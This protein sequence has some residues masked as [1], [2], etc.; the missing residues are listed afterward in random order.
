MFIFYSA[1]LSSAPRL[2]ISSYPP[3]TCFSIPFSCKK[4][5]IHQV[6]QTFISPSKDVSEP[7]FQ[8]EPNRRTTSLVPRSDL[9]LAADVPCR[10]SE[11]V[12][13]WLVLRAGQE[14]ND[15]LPSLSSRIQP[16]PSLSLYPGTLSHAPYW[17]S[18]SLLSVSNSRSRSV[19]PLFSWRV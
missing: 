16:P 9:Q 17:L 18:L 11:S 7:L 12:S 15:F 6:L 13:S 10:S 19:H 14:L 8:R 3:R 4:K 5:K 1:L 2:G